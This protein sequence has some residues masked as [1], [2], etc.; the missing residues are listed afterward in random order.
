MTPKQEIRSP[1]SEIRNSANTARAP[2]TTAQK[3]GITPIAPAKPEFPSLAFPE[4]HQM[5]CPDEIATRLRCHVRH[6]HDLI[7]SGRLR[8]INI[9]DGH[10][11]GGRRHY[12]IPREAWGQYDREN[13]V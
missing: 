1:K 6:V 7:T 5:L 3:S 9:S 8:A 13:T 4:H 12:R 11:A 10:T 2:Q